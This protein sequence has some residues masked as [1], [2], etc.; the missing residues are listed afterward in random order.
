MK[1]TRNRW[2]YASSIFCLR[3]NSSLR[4]NNLRIS[5]ELFD[6]SVVLSTAAVSASVADDTL[7]SFN[8]SSLSAPSFPNNFFFEL[9]VPISPS[10]SLKLSIK[11]SDSLDDCDV[12][13]GAGWMMVHE[14]NQKPAIS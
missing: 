4:R 2:L 3:S 7:L 9:S 1:L 6:D 14:S 13:T 11:I 10:S 5:A 8:C 12:M